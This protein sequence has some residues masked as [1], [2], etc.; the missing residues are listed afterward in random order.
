MRG[1]WYFVS[2]G[3]PQL[4]SALKKFFSKTGPDKE[5]IDIHKKVTE[6]GWEYYSPSCLSFSIVLGFCFSLLTDSG[7]GVP[8]ATPSF[9]SVS[10]SLP[11]LNVPLPALGSF[12]CVT[13]AVGCSFFVFLSHMSHLKVKMH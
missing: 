3:S 10:C 6:P 4:Y 12:L 8:S 13:P 2:N 7:S 5:V 9:I 11:W 1:C